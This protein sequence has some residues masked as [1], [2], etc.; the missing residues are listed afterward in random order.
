[1]NR[2]PRRATP[3]TVESFFRTVLRSG[4]LSR[5]QLQESLRGLPAEERNN[6]EAVA[7]QL[8]KLG[9]L[10][11]F[12][13]RKLLQGTARG[14]VLGPFQV[15][16]PI[17]KG[18]M[19]TVYLAR[20]SRAE[21]QLVALKVL[22]PQKARQE[23]RLL[24][25]FRREMELCQRVAH[26]NLAWTYEVGVSQGIY[27]IAMEFV[28]G[29][30][31]YRVVAD[32]GPLAVPRAARLFAEVAAAL[33]HAH[34]QGLIHRDLKPSNIQ[35]TPHDHAVVL[36]LG[37]ALIE[38]ETVSNR[39]VMG[40]QG[41]VVGTMDYVAPEQCAD[42]CRVDARADIYAL[43]GTL[44]YALTGRP[45][46][47]GGSAREKIQRHRNEEPVPVHHLNPE[48]PVG[49]AA[50]IHRM[51]AKN[52]ERRHPTAA[53]VREELLKWAE[54][55]PALPMDRPTDREYAETIAAL[56]AADPSSD[57]DMPVGE[58]ASVSRPVSAEELPG[59]ADPDARPDRAS[60]STGEPGG[61]AFV[62]L[63]GVG[64]LLLGAAVLAAVLQLWLGE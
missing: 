9:K 32:N 17:G 18:G 36:D 42:A 24:A 19:G 64:V 51:L 33:D 37:L 38:G 50:I 41:Y 27:Y 3:A 54:G 48:V 31:L 53:A 34:N 56:R 7:N 8:V 10:S 58:P 21:N 44:Y 52:P 35:I 6:P 2:P 63:L 30:S 46:F 20:D 11:R 12:Q 57:L 14:L 22:P 1:M 60:P 16:A 43:G 47:P 45:P 26:P 15:L 39:E 25:R 4:L 29:K 55:E 13:A 62:L 23:E 40:G 59:P 28:P 5:E 49:F 61:L